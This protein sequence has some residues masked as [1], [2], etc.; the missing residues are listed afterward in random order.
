MTASP[1]LASLRAEFLNLTFVQVGMLATRNSSSLLPA[2]G[3][4]L[5]A[6]L[7]AP[8]MAR[9]Q[10][11]DHTLETIG[12]ST[13][14]GTVLGASTLPFYDQPGT[15]LLNLVFGAAAGAVV[16]LGVVVH[17]EISGG[18]A[19][20]TAGFNPA[21][22]PVK[23]TRV[24]NGDRRVARQARSQVSSRTLELRDRTS[25]SGFGTLQQ[26]PV[27]LLYTSPSPRD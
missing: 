17:R 24:S 10:S 9:A 4:L 27:C 2:L 26:R 14:V 3:L 25:E 15:H 11:G 20:E 12:I 23:G 16:G 18:S 1:S 22:V 19:D 13:A 21:A 5:G 6:T 7:S 8:R